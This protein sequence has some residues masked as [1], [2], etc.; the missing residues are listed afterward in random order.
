[1]WNKLNSQFAKNVDISTVRQGIFFSFIFNISSAYFTSETH[2]HTH[3]YIYK[4]T[5]KVKLQEQQ[6]QKRDI[7]DRQKSIYIYCR[8]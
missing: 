6:Q 1:M 2:T 5:K 7:D 3:L 8:E 4:Q